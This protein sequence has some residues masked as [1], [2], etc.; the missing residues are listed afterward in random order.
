MKGTSSESAHWA[1][2]LATKLRFVQSSLADDLAETR[3]RALQKELAHALKTVP[4]EKRRN[5]L[6]ALV[7]QFPIPEPFESR[8]QGEQERQ[9]LAVERDSALN[10]AAEKEAAVHQL[11]SRIESQQ[12]QIQQLASERDHLIIERDQALARF[13]QLDEASRQKLA[14][15]DAAQN[16][17]AAER[18]RT[19]SEV[20]GLRSSYEAKIAA[21][22]QQLADV[23]G[24]RDTQ[25][26]ESAAFRASAEAMVD[27]LIQLLR[28]ASSEETDLVTQKLQESR[29]LPVGEPVNVKIPQELK[30]RMK[31]IAEGRQLDPN[32][33]LRALD[34]LSDFTWNVDQLAWQVWKSVAPKS[35]I[36]R[37]NNASGDLR[38]CL[39][40]YLSGD[41]EVSTEQLKQVI[42]KTRK[43]V[44]GLLAAM[45]NVGETYS[46]KIRDRLSPAAIKELAEDEP[47]VFESLEKK[48]WRKFG[49][50]FAEFEG[51]TVEKEIL[52]TIRKYTEKLVLGADAA[53]LEE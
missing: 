10:T 12:G 27:A 50:R 6:E 49:E 16:N 40:P 23:T 31:K 29:L 15:S 11:D 53:S 52:D 2:E 32:R 35:V 25:A 3:Q 44:A 14:Q 28:G 1:T 37:E 30:D 13:D 22:K 24:E 19:K 26:A 5:C 45:G 51:P 7:A 43:L 17:L 46:A 4:Q 41:P 36:H 8:W 33:G 48:C 9:Q 39:G 21:L 20:D 38:K 42:E 34:V 18:D 47:G